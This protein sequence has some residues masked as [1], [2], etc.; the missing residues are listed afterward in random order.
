MKLTAPLAAIAINTFRETVRDRVLYAFVFFAFLVTLAG[1]LLGS[2]SVG[3]DLRVLEDLGLTTI[4]FIGGIIGIFVGT[5]LV[6][7]EIDRRTIYLILTKPVAR[8]Q[9]VAGK[10]LGLAFCLLVVTA[11]MGLFLCGTIYLCSPE[12]V[13]SPLLGESLLLIYLEILFVVAIATFFSTFAT[14][15]MSVVFTIGLWVIGHMVQSLRELAHLSRS[16]GVAR[17]F[18]TLY[19]FMPDLSRLTQIRFDLVYARQPEPELIFYLLSYVVA[20]ILLL[21]TL[22]TL[23][24]ER[25]EFP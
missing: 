11:A 21:L 19:W 17:L 5:S 10:Y 22:S 14:P 24:T 20:Y 23:V 15:L 4:A 12:H 25:R 6:Y 2:L 8:W 13:V 16:A 3:Q 7:K 18:D 9:F 1:I